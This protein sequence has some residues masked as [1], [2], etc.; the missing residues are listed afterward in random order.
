MN[1]ED[2]EGSYLSAGLGMPWRGLSRAGGG[3]WGEGVLVVS[4]ETAAAQM[5]CQKMDGRIA[6]TVILFRCKQKYF[7]RLCFYHFL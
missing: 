3:G 4:A 2:A 6:L 1:E 7:P 5:K